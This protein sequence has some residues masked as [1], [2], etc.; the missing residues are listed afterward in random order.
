[1][2]LQLNVRNV[3]ITLCT[4]II[5]HMYYT[6]INQF[7]LTFRFECN[8]ELQDFFSSFYLCNCKETLILKSEDYDRED[9]C[10]RL[11]NVTVLRNFFIKNNANHM[12][13][14]DY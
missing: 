2:G 5:F 6:N 14:K 1:M 13:T 7:Q 9:F 4:K 3:S 10:P 8:L 11:P 12:A